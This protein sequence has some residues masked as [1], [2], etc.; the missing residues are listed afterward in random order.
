MRE[1]KTNLADQVSNDAGL[2]LLADAI[3]TVFANNNAV[4][5]FDN[6]VHQTTSDGEEEGS[7][8]VLQYQV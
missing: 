4:I 8:T 3:E 2:D 5:G 6:E 7:T 1:W